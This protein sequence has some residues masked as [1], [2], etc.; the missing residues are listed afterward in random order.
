MDRTL[1]SHATSARG[2]IASMTT[3]PTTVTTFQNLKPPF[4]LT[5]IERHDLV[6]RLFIF[7][8]SK[9]RLRFQC[10]LEW[11]RILARIPSSAHT[12]HD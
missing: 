12:C 5:L 9:N 10:M 8:C 3:R 2:L 6:E 4:S 7:A 11:H 1:W